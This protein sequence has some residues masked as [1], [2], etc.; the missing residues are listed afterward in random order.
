MEKGVRM[1]NPHCPQP[2]GP[3]PRLDWRDKWA[4]YA[5]SHRPGYRDL[6]EAVMTAEHDQ[7]RWGEAGAGGGKWLGAQG[8]LQSRAN[9]SQHMQTGC[10]QNRERMWLRP[11]PCGC[12]FL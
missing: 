11:L 12:P 5:R 3:P 6:L 8:V 10:R 2:R 7:H 4:L 1:V 9:A